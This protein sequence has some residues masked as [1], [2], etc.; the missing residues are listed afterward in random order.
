MKV[1]YLPSFVKDLKKLKK[2]PDYGKIKNLIMS[3]IPS[4][5]RLNQIQGLQK[6][7][8]TQNAYRIRVGSY[9]IGFFFQ[10]GTIIFSRVLHRKEIYRFFP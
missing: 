8:G 1:K 5:E 4:Y 2:Q 9:R 3:D 10:E 7:K 6:I